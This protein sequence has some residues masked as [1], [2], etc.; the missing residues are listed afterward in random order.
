M[1]LIPIEHERRLRSPAAAER[2]FR[3]LGSGRVSVRGLHTTETG[4]FARI[5]AAVD[6]NHEHTVSFEGGTLGAAARAALDALAVARYEY[7]DFR[8]VDA[9]LRI[10]PGLRS[11]VHAACNVETASAAF[12]APLRGGENT[13][14]DATVNVNLT[15]SGYPIDVQTASGEPIDWQA[16]GMLVDFPEG[17]VHG[18]LV[19]PNA[20]ERERAAWQVRVEKAFALADGA[21]SVD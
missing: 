10:W 5:I 21:G 14:N 2:W 6:P 15:G 19:T 8:T 16:D 7:L 18:Y 9:S 12:G 17:L 13:V 20:G 4:R 1:T 11:W 3:A